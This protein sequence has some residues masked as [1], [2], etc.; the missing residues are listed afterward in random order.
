MFNDYYYLQVIISELKEKLAENQKKKEDFKTMYF[1]KCLDYEHLHEKFDDKCAEFELK[2]YDYKQMIFEKDQ[3]KISF[4]VE[5]LQE[6]KEH[7][8]NLVCDDEDYYNYIT[9][10]IDNQIKQL[11]EN[12]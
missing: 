5:K 6:V 8:D 2:E 7:N 10:F 11:K 9:A 3:D 12:K 1:N 4:C